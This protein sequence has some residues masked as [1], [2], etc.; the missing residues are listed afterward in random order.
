M[1]PLIAL[2]LFACLSPAAPVPK[3][4]KKK[5]DDATLIVGRWKVHTLSVSGR[6]SNAPDSTFA[7]DRDGQVRIIEGGRDN[8]NFWNWSLDPDGNPPGMRWVMPRGNNN[9][10]CVYE[11]AGDSLKVG[12]VPAGAKRPEMVEPG[13]GI[14]LYEM[15]RLTTER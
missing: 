15:T 12:F 4:L 6:N 9:W 3:A 8:G 13:N 5:A 2:T 11:L 14:T 10:D 7:F 1:R